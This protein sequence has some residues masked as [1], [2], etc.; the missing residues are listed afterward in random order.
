M[1][2]VQGKPSSDKYAIKSSLEGPDVPETTF[3]FPLTQPDY[4][5]LVE[6]PGTGRHRANR[7][8]VA[9]VFITSAL[10][11]L[12]FIATFGMGPWSRT[13]MVCAFTAA[14]ITAASGFL[15]VFFEV[16]AR[17]EGAR[18]SYVECV[19]RIETKLG[20]R[21][22]SARADIQAMVARAFGEN[23]MLRVKSPASTATATTGAQA[24]LSVSG[25]V[26]PK[27]LAPIAPVAEQEKF[28]SASEDWM[29]RQRNLAG[30]DGTLLDRRVPDETRSGT[31]PKGE[32]ILR[33]AKGD[34]LGAYIIEPGLRRRLR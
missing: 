32:Y 2:P 10:T 31:N 24:V 17:K 19:A 18:L 1:K 25:P 6:G 16:G 4:R 27:V 30:P 15:V 7:D 14:A 34:E 33:D 20:I 22:G 26:P 12:G 8:L 21:A 11:L 5:T 13:A 23:V 9:G 29:T 3:V 28:I